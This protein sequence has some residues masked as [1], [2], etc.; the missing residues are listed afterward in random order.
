MVMTSC[1]TTSDWSPVKIKFYDHRKGWGYLT[2]TDGGQDIFFMTPELKA[3][4]IMWVPSGKVIWAKY[5]EDPKGRRA[6][7]LSFLKPQ[8]A[9]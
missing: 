7:A 3:A 4:G 6:S 1:P 2:P 5:N 8:G 9:K